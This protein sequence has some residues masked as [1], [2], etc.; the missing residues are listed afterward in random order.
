[1]RNDLKERLVQALDDFGVG[2]E[3]YDES[4]ENLADYLMEVI[5][6]LKQIQN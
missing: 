1:M 2:Y 5:D 6:E 3:N 4:N